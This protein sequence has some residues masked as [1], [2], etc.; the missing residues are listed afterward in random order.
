MIILG[1]YNQYGYSIFVN[2]KEYYNA[3]NHPQDSSQTVDIDDPKCLPL[4]EIRK[5]CVQTGKEIAK[6]EKGEWGGASKR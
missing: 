6:E 3:G 1:E 2:G 4:K 5:M